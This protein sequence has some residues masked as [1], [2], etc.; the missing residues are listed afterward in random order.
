[1]GEA[2]SV[3]GKY[4]DLDLTGTCLLYGVDVRRHARGDESL[5][6]I[7]Q[8]NLVTG[9]IIRM[10]DFIYNL[11]AYQG[12]GYQKD[13]TILVR[14]GAQLARKRKEDG[15]L[16]KTYRLGN[17][18]EHRIIVRF[19]N[20]RDKAFVTCDIDKFR[21]NWFGFRMDGTIFFKEKNTKF[22]RLA[23]C[24]GGRFIALSKSEEFQIRDIEKTRLFTLRKP[25]R[26][27]TS[28]CGLTAGEFFTRLDW[29]LPVH[30]YRLEYEYELP[31]EGR[32]S[33]PSTILRMLNDEEEEGIVTE[34]RVEDW[35][36]EPEI[37]AD[38][39]ST[40]ENDAASKGGTDQAAETS[41]TEKT[42]KKEGFFAR[43]FRRNR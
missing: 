39:V 12:Y 27:M 17:A 36:R 33:A 8:K 25:V 9:E 19:N 24:F 18:P 23:T 40:I 30:A 6:G 15:K 41:E 10:G 3:E 31:E 11:D 22:S 42:Q 1:M 5:A 21:S 20:E 29:K 38:K 34:V 7:F 14:K 16:L 26:T 13:G 2:A 35:D 4:L 28:A 37:D 43:L 32:I